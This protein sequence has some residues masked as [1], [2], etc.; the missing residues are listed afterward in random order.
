M[1][2]HVDD[3][4]H[5]LRMDDKGAMPA[6]AV[7]YHLQEIQLMTTRLTVTTTN[8]SRDSSRDTNIR[9]RS[10]DDNNTNDTQSVDLKVAVVTATV[11]VDYVPRDASW[12]MHELSTSM[13]CLLLTESDSTR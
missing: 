4:H 6:K 5:L 1:S 7:W 13:T 11:E 2:D 3:H 8:E 10:D 12:L 9:S